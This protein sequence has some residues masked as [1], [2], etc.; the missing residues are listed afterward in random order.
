[1]RRLVPL[2]CALVVLGAA[3]VAH[4]AQDVGT[5]DPSEPITVRAVFQCDAA[6]RGLQAR[7][8]AP[9]DQVTSPSCRARRHARVIATGPETV[10][11]K[12]ERR[13]S[14]VIRFRD[15]EGL[16]RTVTV[17]GPGPGGRGADLSYGGSRVVSNPAS[18]VNAPADDTSAVS[19]RWDSAR[20]H[21]RVI[22][23]G[24]EPVAEQDEPWHT[25]AAAY[26]QVPEGDSTRSWLVQKIGKKASDFGGVPGAK[27]V[28]LYVS[29][30]TGDPAT[31]GRPSWA[32]A[33]APATV[34]SFAL[35]PVGD[36]TFT[37]SA[38]LLAYTRWS[39]FSP[40]G[41]AGYLRGKHFPLIFGSFTFSGYGVYGPGNRYGAP[42][43]VYGRNV[44]IDTL[45]SDYG[46]GWR[47]I[48]G[49]L[50]QPPNGT[51][52]YEIAKKGGSGGR[53]GIS[54]TRTYRLTAIGPALT[55]VVVVT[56][57]GPSFHFGAPDYNPKTMK[58]GTGFS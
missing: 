44:Y 40:G 52:C 53:N 41:Y 49:V 32:H 56:V 16:Q 50:T 26:C 43:T 14:L 45:D 9:V 57:K 6:A 7:L 55:P 46:P 30:W 35:P 54:R 31:P 23:T 58:W 12:D 10:A 4:G 21:A 38:Q 34:A 33:N 22:A 24:P 29:T 20:R 37:G 18:P 5:A 48:M 27:G 36:Q 42:T 1:M 13:S 17:Y 19:C 39:K 15:M 3:S 2:V 51:F 47:R 11:G 25:T 28:T 8:I